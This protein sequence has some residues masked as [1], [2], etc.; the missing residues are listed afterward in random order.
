MVLFIFEKRLIEFVFEINV[1]KNNV[2][3]NNFLLK[4]SKL[5]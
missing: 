2:K 3:A 5:N 4:C 1:F